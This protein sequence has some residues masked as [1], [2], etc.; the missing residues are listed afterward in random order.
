MNDPVNDPVNDPADVTGF[1]EEVLREAGALLLRMRHDPVV[2]LKPGN[3]LVCSADLRSEALIVDA[4]RRRF[5]RDV[6]VA[7]ERGVLMG[8][9][10]RI[11]LV[12]PLDGTGNYVRGL[13]PWG[14]TVAL[15][16]ER[17]VVVG[18]FHDPLEG[19][20]LLAERGGGA[21]LDGRRLALGAPPATAPAVGLSASAP[22]WQGQARNILDHVWDSGAEIRMTG[23]GSAA[24]AAVA[25]GALSAFIEVDGGP[26][27]YAAGALA[28][29][30]A[31]GRATTLDGAEV[32]HTST[33]VLAARAALH[34]ELSRVDW[35]A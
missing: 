3:H 30:E 20:V 7:E 14:V 21:W 18:G 13:R 12:D 32:D 25:T 15:V 8:D 22:P 34:A 35:G 26:W 33:T 19:T 31:G 28:V 6:V 24:L 17:R 29:E 5:P 16:R 9:P 11:W 23:C 10:D 4:L 1:V 27:D 2:S